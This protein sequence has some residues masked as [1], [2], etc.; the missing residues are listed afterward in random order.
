MEITTNKKG[1]VVVHA[2]KKDSP[3]VK[4]VR[5]GDKITTIN[6]QVSRRG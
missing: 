6:G 4:H 3:F 1:F 2:V 5:P